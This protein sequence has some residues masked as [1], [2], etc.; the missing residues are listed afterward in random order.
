VRVAEQIGDAEQRAHFVDKAVTW[1]RADL[2]D[3]TKLLDNGREEDRRWLLGK[4][5]RWRIEASLAGIRE[6]DPV[7]TL[8]RN[9]K[10]NAARSG[11]I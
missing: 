3:W 6:P 5:V 9:N 4:V 7:K 11:G 8:S 2:V 1:L 10:G